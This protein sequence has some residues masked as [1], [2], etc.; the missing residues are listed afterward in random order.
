MHDRHANSGAGGIVAN[1]AVQVGGLN[2]VGFFSDATKSFLSSSVALGPCNASAVNPVPAGTPCLAL[3]IAFER[4][5]K[6]ERVNFVDQPLASQSIEDISA[7]ADVRKGDRYGIASFKNADGTTDLY[8]DELGGIGVSMIHDV[9]TCPPNTNGVGGCAAAIVGGIPSFFPQ[10][11]ATFNDPATGLGQ[12]LYVADVPP[13]NSPPN[14]STVLRYHPDT[15]FTD[16]ISSAVPSYDSLLNPGQPITQYTFI[17][18]LAVNPH[19]GD[20]FIGD[21]P[22]FAIIVNPPLNKGHIWTIPAGAA[23]DC[24]G[25]AI[26]TCDI[27]PPPAQ[28][29]ASL[30]G[31][32][33]TAPKG[34]AVLV[35]GADGQSHLWEADHSAG[36]CRFDPVPGTGIHAINYAACDDGTV[37]GSGGQAAYDPT[38]NPD[39]VTHYIYVAQND[40]LSPGVLRFTYDPT[41]DGGK[42]LVIKSARDPGAQR[43][44]R[45]R[46]GQRRHARS[47]RQERRRHPQG[48][49]LQ[50]R[51]LHRWPGGWLHPPRQ[52]PR[53]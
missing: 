49:D 28:V 37:L 1:S 19:T 6:I 36:F 4:S 43:R 17:V 2:T 46:Q 3:Y 51:A 34:G 29:Q 44:T 50:V 8:I 45:R 5:K 41:L 25:S 16:V 10:G 30:F 13:D 27:P 7:T 32:G 15:G 21:D 18:G 12:Y 52:Q 14:T 40:H 24:V 11:I 38:L 42:G 22:T 9:A 53:G 31:Y 23:P 20:L 48:A 33:V 47:V 39:G 35:P 26:N